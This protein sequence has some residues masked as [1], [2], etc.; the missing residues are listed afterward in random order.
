MHFAYDGFTQEGNRR[1]FL[2]RAAEEHISTGGFSIQVDLGLL[3]KNQIPMQ[4]APMFC[5]NLLTDA[6]LG[7]PGSLDRL[8][9]Y[10]IV[11]DDFKN[12]QIERKR[13]AAERLSKKASRRPIRK[14]SNMSNLHLG[15]F[16]KSPYSRVSPEEVAKSRTGLS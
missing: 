11:G 14:H 3:L 15:S 8:R 2:F 9:S 7:A 12:L 4:E 13:Q 1:C 10:T 6:S 5:L 16:S